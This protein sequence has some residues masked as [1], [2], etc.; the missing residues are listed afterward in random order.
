MQES[1]STGFK[2]LPIQNTDEA[3]SYRLR[4]RAEKDHGSQDTEEDLGDTN[5]P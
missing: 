4:Q 3:D 5:F 2:G 1:A